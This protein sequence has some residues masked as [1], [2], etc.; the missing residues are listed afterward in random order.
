[1][2]KL[3]QI[4]AIQAS[5]KSQAKDAITHAY[6]QL[7]K[8]ETLS[9][10][11]R[12]YKPKDEMGDVLPSENKLVQVKVQDAIS[13]VVTNLVE[14]F[15]VVATQ[16]WANCEAASDV[17]VENHVILA[18]VPVT[19]LLFLEKQ[20]VDI[21]TFV[22]KLPVLDP[23]ER[24]NYDTAQDCFASEPFQTLRTKKVPKT[25]IKYEATKEHP[26]Q[27]E[28]YMEDVTA[29]TWTT[30][31]FSGAIPAAK[32]NAML[33]RVRSL[34]DAVKT[35]RENANGLEVE[36]KKVGEKILKFIF[37]G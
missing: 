1:M 27:V 3:N 6:Q 5:K 4:I 32:K 21:Q 17:V 12:S 14:M 29:G 34:Q 22:E 23:A 33:D 2:P 18:K 31:K 19:H 15:D 35:A 24:W 37:P 30:V 28:M 10:I 36:K 25:H 20:L 7:Q 16:D 8:N 11:S 9:G 13:S 26:A